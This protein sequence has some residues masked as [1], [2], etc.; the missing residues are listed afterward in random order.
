ML[1]VCAQLTDLVIEFTGVSRFGRCSQNELAV[2]L[3]QEQEQSCLTQSLPVAIARAVLS[4]LCRGLLGR[5]SPKLL[6]P[7]KSLPSPLHSFKIW[8]S[9]SSTT[10]RL[11]EHLSSLL[12]ASKSPP[13][14]SNFTR[15]PRRDFVAQ[16]PMQIAAAADAPLLFHKTG[17]APRAQFSRRGASIVLCPWLDISHVTCPDTFYD[18]A[19]CPIIH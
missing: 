6:W 16:L 1:H 9:R 18:C 12:R 7:P 17:I 3:A 2:L 5:S 10:S 8:G 14:P 15:V 19:S 11:A 13:E 4:T